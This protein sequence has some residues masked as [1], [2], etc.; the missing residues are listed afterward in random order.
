M[1]SFNCEKDVLEKLVM[2][3]GNGAK[4]AGKTAVITLCDAGIAAIDTAEAAIDNNP[5]TQAV[6]AATQTAE[7]IL[8]GLDMALMAPSEIAAVV[9]K[10]LAENPIT[11][12]VQSAIKPI[13]DLMAGCPVMKTKVERAET[14]TENM[15]GLLPDLT[16]EDLSPEAP[17]DLPVGLDEVTTEELMT[18]VEELETEPPAT[19]QNVEPGEAFTLAVSLN[20]ATKAVQDTKTESF[21]FLRN[22][23]TSWKN[24]VNS[25]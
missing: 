1:P 15:A 2:Q 22:T 19:E 4:E 16:D 14:E 12:A 24:T 23:F 13:K 21:N 8:G 17:P 5:I 7:T 18:M 25:L 3:L 9:E 20:Q 6:G 10:A 11:Q